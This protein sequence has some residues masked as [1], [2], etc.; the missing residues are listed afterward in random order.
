MLKKK[1]WALV[2]VLAMGASL[3]SAC[4][5]STEKTPES[6][7]RTGDAVTLK[8]I[9]V[10]N[11]MPDN[12]E[13]WL[14][15]INPY[16]E[17][18]IGVNIDIEVVSW[19]DWDSRRAIIVN[20]GEAFDILFTDQNR[21]TA[22]VSTGAFLDI[23]DLV[24]E[25]TP[26]LYDML[27]ED[28]WG[29]A[30]IDGQIYAVPTY[31]DSSATQFFIWDNAVAREYGINVEEVTDYAK[32][33]EAL[34]IIQEGE[35]GSPHYMSRNGADFLVTGY[36][37]QIGAGFPALG[38]KYNDE[39][40]TVVNPLA[41]E[42]LLANMDIIHQ[43][44]LEGI[45]NSDAP[46]ADDSNKY[47][48]FFTAQGWPGAAPSTWG[49]DNGIDDCVAIQFGETVV[50]N[51]TVRGSMNGIS[52][53]S[54]HPEKALEFLQLVNTD[55]KVRDWLYYGVE[56]ENF[57][58]VDGKIDKINSDWSMAGYTQGTF[59]E[60]SIL[61]TDEGNPWEEVRAQ[62]ENAVPSVMLGFDL[63]IS[64]LTTELANVNAVYEKYRYE[65]WTGAQEPRALVEAMQEEL[66]AAGYQTILEA[67]QE[68]V[69]AFQ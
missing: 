22:E 4:G 52:V 57:N 16:L 10:G 49:P 13:S 30:K 46:T 19:G 65:Y 25:K 61:T 15:Q 62:N 63:D 66:D 56:G 59:F 48:T 12:Y 35:G 24:Q 23:T 69:N 43:M 6:A 60:L 37:D 39:T 21:Y 31:K 50:S 53:N 11:A 67:A 20:S 28:Y 36:F 3:L 27:P 38:I 54:E 41:D 34:K 5:G 68:Q 32:L 1:F 2:M 33:H 47:R 29:A 44:Y 14:Q 7:E 9:Q 45:I 55:I 64:E 18:K 58:Y 42:E 17:E 51:T 8:W 26:E 40:R